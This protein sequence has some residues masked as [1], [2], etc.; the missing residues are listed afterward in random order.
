MST[1][2]LGIDAGGSG[3]RGVLAAADGTVLARAGAGPSGSVGGAAGLRLLRGALR[4]LLGSLAPHVDRDS[5]VLHLGLRGLSIAGRREAALAAI[6]VHLPHARVVV[7]NDAAIALD[8]ALAGGPGVVVLA[9]TGSIALAKR[10]DGK[11][12][13]AGGFGYLVGDEGSGFWLGREAIA[14]S[15]RAIDGRGPPTLLTELLRSA[16]GGTDLVPWTYR[17]RQPVP[18]IAALAPLVAEAA[19]AGDAIALELLRRAAA[20]LA[21]LA[22]AVTTRAWRESPPESLLIAR[23]GGVWDA[24]PVLIEA[25]DAALPSGSSVAPRL[26][27]V[28]GA[29]LRALSADGIRLTDPLIEALAASL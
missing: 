13:R 21:S 9:G 3:T 24:G 12:L 20:E 8:G 27:P 7:T 16:T 2:Y 4:E 11:E 15:L 6:A 29:V 25:F 5:C 1:L 14:A 17:H 26:P 19:T 22:V 10:A 18:R 28:G 23:C